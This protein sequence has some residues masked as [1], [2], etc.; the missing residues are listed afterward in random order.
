L[1]EVEKPIA[2]YKTTVA[3][4]TLPVTIQLPRLTATRLT[5]AAVLAEGSLE[6]LAARKL[7]GSW[8]LALVS[9]Q[10]RPQ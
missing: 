1:Q 9:A 4:T 3:G 7:D 2:E 5:Q 6:V 8:L 10:A